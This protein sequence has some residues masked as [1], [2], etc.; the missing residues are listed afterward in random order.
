MI[1]LICLVLWFGSGAAG[2]WLGTQRFR[3][4]F[5]NA[6]GLDMPNII[7]VVMGPIGLCGVLFFIA[8]DDHAE[9]ADPEG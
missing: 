3:R 5:G 1:P 7:T 8:A 4:R 6:D 9:R 2:A